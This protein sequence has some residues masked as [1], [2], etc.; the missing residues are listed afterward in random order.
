[1]QFVFVGSKQVVTYTLEIQMSGIEN[2]NFFLVAMPSMAT[3]QDTV[4]AGEIRE[5]ST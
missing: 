2:K 4:V 3:K 5:K 1:M